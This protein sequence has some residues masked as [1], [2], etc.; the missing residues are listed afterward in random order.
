[1]ASLLAEIRVIARKL[2]TSPAYLKELAQDFDARTV[3]PR[4]EVLMHHYAWGKP[5]ETIHVVSQDDELDSMSLEELIE[6]TKQ[7]EGQL[8]KHAAAKQT[9]SMDDP[10]MSGVH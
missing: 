6:R 1:M 10:A 8:T 9:P 5:V 2:V 7:I 3:D 4:I